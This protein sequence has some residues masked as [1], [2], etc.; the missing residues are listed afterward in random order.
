MKWILLFFL[1]TQAFANTDDIAI[2]MRLVEDRVTITQPYFVVAEN[3]WAYFVKEDVVSI[4][5]KARK[6]VLHR[7]AGISMEVQIQRPNEAVS[8]T[9][10]VSLEEEPVEIYIQGMERDQKALKLLLTAKFL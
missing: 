3:E 8:I 1:G 10:L 5:V 2:D 4:Q 9:H 7:Q 6:K